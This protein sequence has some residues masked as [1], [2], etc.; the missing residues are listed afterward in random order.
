LLHLNL[1]SKNPQGEPRGLVPEPI[2]E[3]AGL[4]PP[5]KLSSLNGRYINFYAFV[6]LIA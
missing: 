3:T 4:Y 2:V 5:H 6:G 1:A